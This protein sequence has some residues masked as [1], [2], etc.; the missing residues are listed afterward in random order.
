MKNR[1]LQSQLGGAVG[2]GNQ[3]ITSDVQRHFAKILGLRNGLPWQ[4]QRDNLNEIGTFLGILSGSMGKIAK[5]ISLLMQTEVGEV[6]EGAEVGKGGSSTMPHK[7]NPVGCALILAN[8][9][10]T[11]H[12]V[13]T[14]LAA[15]PQEHERSAGLWHA[16]WEPLIQLFGL[17][18]GSLEIS[19][20]LIQNLE[21]DK[22]RMLSNI[23][24]T[25]G[26][27]YAEMA[28]FELAKSMGKIQ[29][30]ETVQK[31][32]QTTLAKGKHLQE[33]L[34]AMNLEIEDLDGLFQPENAIGNAMEWTENVIRKYANHQKDEN[35]L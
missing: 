20:N 17:T 6:F 2:S 34:A 32:C 14:L 18:A 8:S 13:A 3:N 35:K 21:V 25:N 27:I 29:A 15:M 23:E 26:L 24:M 9:L 11:P 19:V 1:V 33:V 10:R 4:S 28:S 22:A 5:D 7:R 31:A 16:E 12:L 30:H